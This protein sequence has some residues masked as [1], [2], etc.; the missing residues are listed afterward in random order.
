[1]SSTFSLFRYIVIVHPMR[2]RALCTLT[3][4][5]LALLVIWGLSLI[6][7]LPVAYTNVRIKY[8][9]YN[10]LLVLRLLCTM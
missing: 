2:S 9:I 4:C 10:Q 3:N 1:M 7:A 5:R 8:I 6:L